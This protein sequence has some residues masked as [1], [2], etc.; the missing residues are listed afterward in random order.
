[1]TNLSSIWHRSHVILT[2]KCKPQIRN[3]QYLKIVLTMKTIR[4]SICAV[5]HTQSQCIWPN[6]YSDQ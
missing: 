1:M 5:F 2:D 4:L 3:A 6:Q